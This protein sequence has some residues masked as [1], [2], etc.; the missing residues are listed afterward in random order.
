MTFAWKHD[1]KFYALNS[2]EIFHVG[3][4]YT[5]RNQVTINGKTLGIGFTYISGANE[6]TLKTVSVHENQGQG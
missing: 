4:K 6:K 1:K 3:S 2:V 5:L